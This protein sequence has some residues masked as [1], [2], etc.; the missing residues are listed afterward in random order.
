MTAARFVVLDGVDGSGKSTQAE[1]L[2]RALTRP[3]A[4]PPLR[5]RQPGGTALGERIRGLLLGREHDPRPAVETLLLAA[6]RRQLLEEVV[7]PALAGGRDVVCDRFHASTFAYQAY[8]GSV[9]EDEVLEL[10]ETWS[11]TPAPDV[12]LVLWL[13]P[14]EALRRRGAATDRIEDRGLEF[15][16]RVAAG[17]QR[18]AERVE[19]AKLIDAS[20]SEDDVARRIAA[21]VELVRAG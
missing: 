9:G 12:E 1:R 15:Q 20:G 10:L 14:D 17:Y 6:D 3:G 18:Y 4:P 21:E 13:P 19:R 8:A 2:V 7:A 11:G 16:R 5:V